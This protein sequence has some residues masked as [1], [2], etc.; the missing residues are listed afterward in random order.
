M[1]CKGVSVARRAFAWALLLPVFGLLGAESGGSPKPVHVAIIVNAKNGTT[2]VTLKQLRLIFTLEQQFWPKSGRIL[3]IQRSS[4]TLAGQAVLKGVY[5]MTEDQLRKH[6]VQKL[7]SGEIPAIPAVVRETD[8]AILS[9]KKNEAAITAVIAGELP[10]G[11]RALVV[12]GKK[13][14]EE[15]YPLVWMEESS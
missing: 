1:G 12:D 4:R 7:F 8:A 13:P 10:E 2:D 6:W 5:S 14:G 11:V 15:G 3:L 9:T